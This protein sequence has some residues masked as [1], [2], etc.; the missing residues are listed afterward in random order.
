MIILDIFSSKCEHY[1]PLIIF[2][3]TV[4]RHISY[5]YTVQEILPNF[6]LLRGRFRQPIQPD[7]AHIAITAVNGLD[8]IVSVNFEHIAR[9]WTVEKVRKVNIREV[10]DGIR[11]FAPFTYRN[12]Y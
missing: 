5:N 1:K 9:L 2:V 7:A 8:F 3:N 4:S 6:I 10:F 11:R 12:D